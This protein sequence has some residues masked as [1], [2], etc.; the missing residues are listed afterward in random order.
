MTTKRNRSAN[1]HG[2]CRTAPAVVAILCST[3][4]A[5]SPGTPAA[6]SLPPVAVTAARSTQPV[7]DLLADL[8]VIGADEILRSG[9]QSL[10]QLLQRQPGVEVTINGGPGATSGAFLRGANRGQTLVLVDGLRVGSSSVG[11]TSLEAIPLDQID[12]VEILR[13]PASS[14]Y[15]ADAIGGV[16]QVFTK[17]ASGGA[18]AGSLAAGYGT[19]DTRTLSGGLS[20]AM[21]PLAFSA[22]AGGTRSAGFNA[23][24]DPG[25][26]SY[27]GD[28]DG[29]SAQNASVN[30]VLPWA[31]GQEVA[32][33]YLQNRLNSQYDGGPGFDDRTVTTLETWAVVSRNR[34]TGAWTT[35]LTAGQG[36]DDSVSQTGYGDYP[37]KTTQRQLVWQNDAVLALG[38]ASVI[39]ERRIE[40]LATDDAF[41]LTRR[42]TNSATGVYRLRHEA[43][44]LQANLRYD[45][46]SQYDG[47][48]TG[49]I[50]VGYRIS[51][52]WRVT[53]GFSTGFK[54]PSFNDLYYPG[55]SNPHLVPETA[56]NAEIGVYWTTTVGAARWEARGLAYRNRVDQLIV[57]QCDAEFDCRPENVDRATLQGVTLGVEAAWRETR[58]QAS[59]DLQDPHD[60][61]TGHLLP[62]RARRHGALTLQ[63]QAGPIQLGC[64]FVASSLRYDDLAN[65][66]KMGGY[67]IVN[68]T[69][70]WPLAKRWSL[71]VRGNNVFDKNYQLAEGY[72]TG[73]ATVFAS[74][75]WQ[76]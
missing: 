1:V 48:A 73:G 21:G 55:F 60:D 12:R 69:A 4:A 59:L 50:A 11:A 76:P 28:R 29:Y 36:S 2:L 24:V 30:A 32:V 33:Q 35:I 6:A 72:A 47:Q 23:I 70:E 45:D 40:D 63:Q 26:F 17:K 8:T 27:N 42:T 46:S 25:N 54:A 75:R 13:G 61:R 7:A 71:L 43:F 31:P 39:A 38:S 65:T 51:P 37:Y 66:R 16:I 64:E 22:Q 15:G 18:F 58:V 19:Y 41:A 62:R 67:G 9:A 49:A 56:R 74:L 3:A 10:P 57:F 14:L 53:A 44:A 20:G 68:L 52:A 5:Q 34:L